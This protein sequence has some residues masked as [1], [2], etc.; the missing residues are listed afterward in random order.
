[1]AIGL[2]H[3]HLDWKQRIHHKHAR[4]TWFSIMFI[5]MIYLLYNQ[6]KDTLVAKNI[7]SVFQADMV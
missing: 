6:N 5:R 3:L 1:M 2:L 7:Y 4:P